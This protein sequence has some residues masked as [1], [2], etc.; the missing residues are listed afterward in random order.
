VVVVC[1]LSYNIVQTAPGLRCNRHFYL[2]HSLAL[3][4]LSFRNCIV[5][6][7]PAYHD[8]QHRSQ[9]KPKFTF[10]TT[11]PKTNMTCIDSD[12]SMA[13]ESDD[14]DVFAM[15]DDDENVAPPQQK[16]SKKPAPKKSNKNAALVLS[17]NKNIENVST[18]NSNKIKKDKKTVEETYQK[19]SQL[20]HVLLR[21][22]TYIGSVE[23]LTQ[24]MF[25]LDP[26]TDRIVNRE[27][28]Y[29]PGL[30]KIYDESTF[31]TVGDRYPSA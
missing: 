21:P 8:R 19:M 28:T 4:F 12:F 7:P 25:V 27:I 31:A 15:S 13:V 23:P 9:S 30:Y 26:S 1:R 10:I 20:E 24:P 3:T 2:S 22:D 16:V 14:D 11:H 17:P 5:L 29:T 6:L 18:S